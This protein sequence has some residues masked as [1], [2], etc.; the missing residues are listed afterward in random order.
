MENPHH[1]N[2][3]AP[4]PA[5]P[6]HPEA[7]CPTFTT[8]HKQKEPQN[9]EASAAGVTKTL[10]TPR[11]SLGRGAAVFLVEGATGEQATPEK[12]QRAGAQAQ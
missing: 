8:G 11:H 4:P 12:V 9:G 7:R 10:E 1:G 6:L 2:G 3:Q 5:P